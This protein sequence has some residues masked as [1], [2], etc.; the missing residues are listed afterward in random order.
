MNLRLNEWDE[1]DYLWRLSVIKRIVLLE[2]KDRFTTAKD[3]RNGS[4][5]MVKLKRARL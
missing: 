3:I 2:V 1:W 4:K 5:Y